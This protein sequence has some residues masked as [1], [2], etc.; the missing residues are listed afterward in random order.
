MSKL[1]LLLGIIIG[2]TILSCSS[3]NDEP[4]N[5]TPQ[6]ETN[7]KL[8]KITEEG[9]YGIYEIIYAY[10]SDDIVTEIE[11]S[12]TEF[13]QN[14]PEDIHNVVYTYENDLVISAIVYENDELYLTIAYNYINDR[15]TEE[16][17]YTLNGMEDEKM[18]YLYNMNDEVNGFNYYVEEILQQEMSYVYS[19]GNITIAEDSSDHLEISY[20]SNP[21]PYSNFSDTNKIIFGPLLIQSLSENNIV[22][23]IR[24]YNV[25]SSNESIRNYETTITYDSDNYPITKILTETYNNNTNTIRT[26]I[27][28]YE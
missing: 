28:E 25:G 5:P 17:R 1:N 27:F 24:T 15:L 13:G 7:K 2:L 8:I 26:T 6:D 16:I 14:I 4:N 11:S 21:T 3:D 23:E 9:T 22:N 19:N 12:F 20:D 18:V 10:N